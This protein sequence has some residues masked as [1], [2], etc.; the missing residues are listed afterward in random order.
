V[1]APASA[2]AKAEGKRPTPAEAQRNAEVGAFADRVVPLLLP[3]IRQVESSGGKNNLGPETKYG[4]AKGPYQLLDSTGQ[5]YHRAL[6]LP[7]EYDPFDERQSKR[8]AGALL[9]DL[10]ATYRGDVRK[11]VLAYN[12]GQGNV[13]KGNIGPQGRAYV[14]KVFAALA[15]QAA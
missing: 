3:A 11:A 8:I 1:F 2:N 14:P 9:S 4:R 5:F 6:R 12:Q 7:G 13:D 15:R 10:I